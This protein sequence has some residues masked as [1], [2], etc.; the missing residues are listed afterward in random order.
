M[1]TIKE[2]NS[3]LTSKK[4]IQP[5]KLFCLLAA[6]VFFLLLAYLGAHTIINVSVDIV[7][8][9]NSVESRNTR[10]PLDQDEKYKPSQYSCKYA[11][12]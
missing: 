6:G 12:Y 1:G 2:I 4:K 8:Q 9:V 3:F 10:D 7:S 11:T 5:Q